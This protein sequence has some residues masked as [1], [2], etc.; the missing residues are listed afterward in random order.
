MGTPHRAAAAA[1]LQ[2]GPFVDQG[3]RL[4]RQ[5][6]DG[7]SITRR[8]LC[9]CVCAGLR[10]EGLYASGLE[11]GGSETLAQQHGKKLLA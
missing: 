2:R 11:E 1:A 10:E 6:S 7:Q 3:L 5:A 4:G 8:A 9:G